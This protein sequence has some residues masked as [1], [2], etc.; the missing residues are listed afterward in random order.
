MVDLSR[1]SKLLTAFVKLSDSR[2]PDLNICDLSQVLVHEATALVN[3]QAGSLIMTDYSHE[4]QVAAA[5]SPQAHEVETG[6][7]NANTGPSVDSFTTGRALAV[8]D[9]D[10]IGTRWQAFR[11]IAAAQGLRSAHS[12][13]LK[14]DGYTIGVLSLYNTNTGGLTPHE[15]AV[16]QALTD[17]AATT[18]VQRRQIDEA[19]IA[20][21]Q[22]QRALD[23]RIHIEQAK[24][25]ISALGDLSMDE[26]FRR[27][28]NYARENNRE[29]HQ[30]AK[31]VINRSIDIVDPVTRQ[32]T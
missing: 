3:G 8:N 5:T 22:L 7:L 1:E 32:D 24:G 2:L 10:E 27:L 6:Q 18:V 13:P 21:E 11:A 26:A 20:A 30:V 12:T 23:S 29:L 15:C 4:L 14:V 19:E 9:I 17:L 28:R 31:D 25:V 16:V